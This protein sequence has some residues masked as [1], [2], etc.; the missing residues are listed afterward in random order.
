MTLQS[1]WRPKQYSFLSLEGQ[2]LCTVNRAAW[3]EMHTLQKKDR[4]QNPQPCCFCTS[5]RI[6]LKSKLS[7]TEC[8]PQPSRH[9]EEQQGENKKIGTGRKADKLRITAPGARIVMSDWI[10][11]WKVTVFSGPVWSWVCGFAQKRQVAGASPSTL[12]HLHP[13]TFQGHHQRYPRSPRGT[14]PSCRACSPSWWCCAP[15]YCPAFLRW[16]LKC[17]PEPQIQMFL[18]L[19]KQELGEDLL[20]EHFAANWCEL[21]M[22]MLRRN[23][24]LIELCWGLGYISAWKKHRPGR[25]LT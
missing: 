18:Y 23:A 19:I 13:G 4:E 25:D 21:L 9:R 7:G 24:E 3:K 12:P 20:M 15:T 11:P 16:G 2:S 22:E 10:A 17:T 14:T 6:S 8:S 1:V 5:R